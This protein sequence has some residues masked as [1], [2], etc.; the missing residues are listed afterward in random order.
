MKS[1]IVFLFIIFNQ[2]VFSQQNQLWKS[3]YS[4]N[5][6]VDVEGG[7]NTVFAATTNSI[8]YKN[9]SLNDL[10]IYNSINGF[11]PENITTIH[12]SKQ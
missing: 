6:I 12:H 8:F 5:E 4:Y 1:K 3:Y 11:K 9:L 7:V 2:F 10:S